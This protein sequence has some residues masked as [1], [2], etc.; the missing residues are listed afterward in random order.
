MMKSGIRL[1]EIG[2]AS[3]AVVACA[4]AGV[5]SPSNCRSDSWRSGG[6]IAEVLDSASLTKQLH[7][8]ST[9][10][11]GLVIATLAYD[12]LGAL[13]DVSVQSRDA[14]EAVRRTLE[15]DLR[16]DARPRAKENSRVYLVLSDEGG[17]RPRR[18][19]RF[20]ACLPVIRD[21][22]RLAA[23]LER[24]AVALHVNRRVTVG[25]LAHVLED[26]AV[27]ETR[28]DR[29]SGDRA[30]DLG[31]SRVLR[32]AM[33]VPAMV[34]GIPVAVWASFPINFLPARSG[35]VEVDWSATRLKPN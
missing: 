28:V 26:G 25:V 19:D 24:E 14:P 6:P 22:S 15:E 16:S 5:G 12:S 20:R 21:R 30:I 1:L 10:W 8:G 2:L 27:N 34:E 4:S 33:F 17:V 29:S 31:A 7:N 18:V 9:Q 11:S 13:D 3:T 23:L 32:Q 35:R